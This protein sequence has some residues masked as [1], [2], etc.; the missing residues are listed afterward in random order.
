MDII[1]VGCGK[2]GRNLAEQ[3][4][5]EEG[6]NLVLID[7]NAEKINTMCEETDAMGI[8]GNGTSIHI[9]REAGIE[10]ADILIAITASDEVN[11]LC[12]LIAQQAGKPGHCHTIARVRNPIYN[13]E[14]KFIKERLGI[15]MIINPELAA[16]QEISRLLSLPFA[17][18]IDIFAKGKVE[19][20]QFR[21]KPEFGLG[22]LSIIQMSE[23]LK[24]DI[25]VCAVERDD[26]ITIPNGS[27]VLQDNDLLS[28]VAS[29][30]NAITFFQKIGMKTNKVRSTLLLGGGTTTFYLAKELMEMGISV[31]IVEKDLH[32]CEQLSELLPNAIVIHGNATDKR[33]LLEEGLR[34][35]ESV[36]TLT[37]LDEE[38][39]F[40]GLYAKTQT[41]AKII[42]RVERLSYDEIIDNLDIGSVVYPKFLTS[43]F[44][45]QYVRSLK[46]S[47][48]SNIE[49]LYHILDNRAE[50][51]EFHVHETPFSGT[52]LAKLNLKDNLLLCCISR[53]GRIFIPRGQDCIESGDSVV[54]VTTIKGLNDIRD[55]VK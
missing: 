17:I 27:F 49:T 43:D 26:Q 48:G 35:T 1:I 55:I 19:L 51:L 47:L 41:N 42:A 4:S 10:T 54:V 12:C 28:I 50:A 7:T 23:K 39:I 38:N 2:V 29:P 46:N 3:L 32:R 31:K 36:V 37:N 16:A 5:A 9:L 14:I 18:N 33:L 44:I 13:D 20:L 11:L 30:Q 34:M 52:P 53:S 21:L 45:S 8:I 6:I 24:C 25:L 40:L 15:S 22:G